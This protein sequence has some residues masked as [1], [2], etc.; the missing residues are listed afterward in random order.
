MVLEQT[1]GAV[2]MGLHVN[3]EPPKNVTGRAYI[4]AELAVDPET[5]RDTVAPDF[6]IYV[7]LC[8]VRP[9]GVR[10]PLSGFHFTPA[11]NATRWQRTEG[12]SSRAYAYGGQVQVCLISFFF[13]TKN[14]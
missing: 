5:G 3:V 2:Q 9:G 8:G 7:V 10:V 11:A 1:D 13:S 14:L 4:R 6:K 12:K